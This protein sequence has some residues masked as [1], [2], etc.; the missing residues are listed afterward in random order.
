MML[1]TKKRSTGRG[2]STSPERGLWAAVLT[3][4]VKDAKRGSLEAIDWMRRQNN[5]DRKIDCEN[6]DFDEDTIIQH[7]KRL[8][9]DK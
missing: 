8:G 6:A 9:N 1:Q 2:A 5:I 7:G 4:V 3:S